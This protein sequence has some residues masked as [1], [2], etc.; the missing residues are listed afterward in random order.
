MCERGLSSPGAWG[1]TETNL[2]LFT[3]G[4]NVGCTPAFLDT[5][6]GLVSLMKPPCSELDTGSL[7]G[8]GNRVSTVTGPEELRF[9]CPLAG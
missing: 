4:K 9:L 3:E 7:L 1:S 6:V 5:P 8:P 2:H